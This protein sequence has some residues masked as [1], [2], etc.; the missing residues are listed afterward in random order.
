MSHRMCPVWIG[1]LIASPLR[2]LV[3]KPEMILTGLVEMGMTVLDLGPGMGFFSLPMARM[4][5]PG[6]RVIC[7]DTQE[8]MLRSLR[9]R[10][11]R[12]GLAE[13]IQTLLCDEDSLGLE[14]YAGVIDFA[15][16]FAMVHEVP[17]AKKLF[18]ET[19]SAL[20]KGGTMLVAEPRGHVT[21]PAF[22]N[23]IHLAEQCGFRVLRYPTI[24]SS[25][26]VLLEK[27]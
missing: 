13:Q 24:R 18:A 22:A 11:A 16:A 8:G 21:E 20:K 6:G 19:A 23:T 17:D 10:A 15:L 26:A 9:R 27:T 12:V 7:V 5:G 2:K 3:H 14:P 25:R 1:Y 4:A